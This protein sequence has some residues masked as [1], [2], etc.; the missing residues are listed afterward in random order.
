M[1]TTEQECLSALHDATEI[2]GESPTKAQYEDL[3]LTPASATIMRVV[4]GWNAAKE[5]AGLETYDKSE[6]GGPSVA[7]KP[8]WVDLPEDKVW[9]D[10]SG[11]QR[12]YYKNRRKEIDKKERRRAEMRRWVHDYKA[13]ECE[14][15]RCGE[16]DPACLDFHHTG[17][18]E[19]SVSNMVS[20][21]YGKVALRDEIER[22]VVL[23]ANCHRKEHYEAPSL[24][25]DSPSQHS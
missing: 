4:G 23:C 10:L 3:G 2:L 18:K 7:P 5:R 6:Y 24:P 14:C 1:E 8:D 13:A 12:W 16:G 19:L 9:E 25:D 20:Y 21:G 11:N 17:E 22:C 15:A